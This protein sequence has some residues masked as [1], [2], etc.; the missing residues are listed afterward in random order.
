MPTKLE[1]LECLVALLNR[2]NN[3]LQK[4]NERLQSECTRLRADLTRAEHQ[5]DAIGFDED[6][7]TK[8]I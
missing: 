2:R 6:K 7:S 4:E 8:Q 1:E 5:L 3:K